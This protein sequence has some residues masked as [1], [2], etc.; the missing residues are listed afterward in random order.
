MTGYTPGVVPLTTVIAPVEVF[1]EIPV[2]H[3]PL[4]EIVEL[5]KVEGNPLVESF[6]RTFV[7]AT[8]PVDG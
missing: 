6:A 5:L 3:A 7:S 1:N 8:P 2:G 4:C